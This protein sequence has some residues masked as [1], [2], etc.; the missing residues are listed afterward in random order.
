MAFIRAGRIR[1]WSCRPSGRR[2]VLAS[3]HRTGARPATD[4]RI[5]A[6]A[7]RVDRQLVDLGVQRHVVVGPRRQRV[8]LDEVAIDVVAD[9]RRVGPGRAVDADARP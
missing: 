3:A 4:R 8:D 2:A 9:D 1:S 5:A 7:E 6:L